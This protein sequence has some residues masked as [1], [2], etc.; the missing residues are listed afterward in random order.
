MEEAAAT[1][2]ATP[3]VSAI[4]RLVCGVRPDWRGV[5]PVFGLVVADNEG[6]D[7]QTQE[8]EDLFMQEADSSTVQFNSVQPDLEAQTF[9]RTDVEP[10]TIEDDVVQ[11]ANHAV[12]NDFIQELEECDDSV[13]KYEKDELNLDDVDS[14]D[15]VFENDDNSDYE[16]N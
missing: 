16:S 5:R 7:I 15:D 12:H 13:E 11:R 2:G 9:A 6:G 3:R 8:T 10:I 4:G 1:L 14:E